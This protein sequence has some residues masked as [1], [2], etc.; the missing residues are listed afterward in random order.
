MTTF[1]VDTGANVS[2][3]PRRFVPNAP[4]MKLQPAMTIGGFSSAIKPVLVTHKVEVTLDF[5]PGT[6]K[7]AF[8]I[9]DTKIPTLG[10]D[11]LRNKELKLS[12]CTGKELLS[13]RQHIIN[14]KSTTTASRKEY[15][16][17]CGMT[18]VAYSRE[19]GHPLQTSSWMRACVG[20]YSATAIHNN[21]EGFR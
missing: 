7:T 11:I 16:R 10:N 3:L 8:Y 13:I 6:L 4:L 2:I 20:D 18:D 15:I 12:L 14:T 1:F 19:L 5:H 9:C 21:S 17:R